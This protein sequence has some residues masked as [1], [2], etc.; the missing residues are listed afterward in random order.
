[1]FQQPSSIPVQPQYLQKVGNAK[2]LEAIPDKKIVQGNNT[3]VI[4]VL[5][6]W[7]EHP[8]DQDIMRHPPDQF[9]SSFSKHLYT[10]VSLFQFS[11]FA[12]VS[13][14]KGSSEKTFGLNKILLLGDQVSSPPYRKKRKMGH[15][16]ETSGAK[17]CPHLIT[18]LSLD[19]LHK[20]LKDIQLNNTN[21][22]LV[23]NA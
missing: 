12:S 1:M 18:V 3:V 22:E 15:P 20:G 21:E 14:P 5:N 10:L 6:Q 9:Y 17:S 13:S 7:K 4:T 8:P 16:Q 11:K 2:R 19:L 23:L